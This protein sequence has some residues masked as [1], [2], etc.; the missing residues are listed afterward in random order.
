MSEAAA[1]YKNFLLLDDRRF[2]LVVLEAKSEDK[3][4]LVGKEQPAAT[5]AR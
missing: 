5:P 4:P 3:N 2:P 1:R